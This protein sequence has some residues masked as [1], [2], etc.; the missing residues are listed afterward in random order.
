[1][2]DQQVE[3]FQ[4]GAVK[5]LKGFFSFIT[6]AAA[7]IG[8]IAAVLWYAVEP[9]IDDWM[10]DRDRPLLDRLTAIEASLANIQSQITGKKISVIEFTGGGMVPKPGPFKPGQTVA[11]TYL[12]RRNLPCAT[13]VQARFLEGA[14]GQIDTSLT[15]EF[16][17]TRAPVSREYSLFTVRLRLPDNI[18]PGKW[19]YAPLLEPKDCQGIDN[20]Q[21]PISEFFQ[22]EK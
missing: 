3:E 16:T 10:E 5:W 13:R 2:T 19:S 7:A 8:I 1:M 4:A 6:A 21:P 14:T 22:V 17:A 15:Y 11:I 9:R 12:L 18:R 20:V